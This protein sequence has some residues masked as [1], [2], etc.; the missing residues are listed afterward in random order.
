M[1]VLSERYIVLAID[2]NQNATVLD[3]QLYILMEDFQ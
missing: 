1:K 2:V 3:T